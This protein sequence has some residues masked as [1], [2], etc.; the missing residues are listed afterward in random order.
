MEGEAAEEE[1]DRYPLQS[2]SQRDLQ[3]P[4]LQPCLVVG[5]NSISRKLVKSTFEYGG[6]R[7]HSCVEGEDLHQSSDVFA[8]LENA[9]DDSL[10]EPQQLG[11][12]LDQNPTHTVVREGH[13][14][15]TC[16]KRP[17]KSIFE[18]WGTPKVADVRL[19]PRSAL[20]KAPDN[21]LSEPQQL[22]GTLDQ[23]PRHTVDLQ[24]RRT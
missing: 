17:S 15:P 13:K 4:A 5:C 23:N 14:G 10:N 6:T 2:A 22:G 1:K 20:E 12:T 24:G 11:S 21:S 3:A 18:Y 7:T 19:E 9:P 8:S 16:A